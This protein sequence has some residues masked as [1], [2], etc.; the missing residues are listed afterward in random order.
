[1]VRRRM[2]DPGFWDNPEIGVEHSDLRL[3][4]EGTWTQA[5]D[6]G[7][8]LYDVK[9]LHRLVFGYRKSISIKRTE[10]LLNRLITPLEKLVPYSVN[11]KDYLFVKDFAIYQKLSHPSLSKLPNPPEN[12]GGCQKIPEDAST[13]EVKLS[14]VKLSKDKVS[15]ETRGK[16]FLK[17]LQTYPQFSNIIYG[18]EGFFSYWTEPNKSKTKMRFEMQKT[19]DTKRRLQRWANNDFGKKSPDRSAQIEKERQADE[20]K[21]KRWERD[22][23]PPPGGTSLKGLLQTA[24]NIGKKGGKG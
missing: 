7:K 5:D 9:R 12:S 16:D 11:G 15:M 4:Y 13:K 6:E 23:S 18:P 19:W 14:K 2:L 22:Q 8:L 1:M 10:M 21:R 3:L 17:E 24:G 20:K